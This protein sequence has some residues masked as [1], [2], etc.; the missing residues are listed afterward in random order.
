MIAT[1]RTVSL[2]EWIIACLVFLFCLREANV[3][4]NLILIFLATNIKTFPYDMPLWDY[5]EWCW[6]PFEV[7]IKNQQMREKYLRTFIVHNFVLN[8]FVNRWIYH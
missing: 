4:E 7:F 6:K 1:G 8:F 5:E 3:G 2:A